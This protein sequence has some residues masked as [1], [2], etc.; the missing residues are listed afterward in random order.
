MDTTGT[1]T[2]I[3]VPLTE[4]RWEDTTFDFRG[5]TAAPPAL[6]DSIRTLGVLQP[7]ILRREEANYTI[8]AGFRRARICR[9]LSLDA[10]PATVFPADTCAAED[11]ARIAV[12]AFTAGEHLSVAR[13]EH[14]LVAAGGGQEQG[15]LIG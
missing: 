11:A 7:V 5:D 15:V 10:L 4:I 9:R 14:Q 2:L 6:E 13:L 3:T 12:T 1:A 8:L